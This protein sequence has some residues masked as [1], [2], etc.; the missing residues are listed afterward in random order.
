MTLLYVTL[1]FLAG[2]FLGGSL[3][4]FVACACVVA[5]EAD[6][7]LETFSPERSERNILT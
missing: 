4:V 2:L 7:H 6:A 3:G 5:K 1:A